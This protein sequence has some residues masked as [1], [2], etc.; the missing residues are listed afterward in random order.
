MT[1]KKVQLITELTTEKEWREFVRRPGLLV[2]DLYRNWAG[3]C[4]AMSTPLKN[5][6]VIKMD[7][8]HQV[9]GIDYLLPFGDAKEGG[10]IKTFYTAKKK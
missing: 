8:N 7:K 4:S 10:G 9:F 5:L 3:P 1:T 2:I 6:K